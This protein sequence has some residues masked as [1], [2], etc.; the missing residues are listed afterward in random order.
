MGEVMTDS[1][2]PLAELNFGALRTR[3]FESNDA[4][5]RVAAHDAARIIMTAIAERGT[6]NVILATGNSQLT[7]LRHLRDVELE[8]DKVK[9]FHLDQYVGI[10]PDHPASFTHFLNETLL[11]FVSVGEFFPISGDPAAVDKTCREY[12]NLLI[13]NPPDLVALGIGE[14]GHLAFNDPPQ[15]QFDDPALVRVVDLTEPSRHQQVGEGHF[16]SLNDV[17]SKAIT[18]TIPA[19][20]AARSILAI[21]PETRKAD[22]VRRCL[23]QPISEDVPGTVLRLC[24]NASLYLDLN[25]SERVLKLPLA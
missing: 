16:P 11:K 8:W 1:I 2:K 14:N 18:L 12:E 9:V 3:V 5:G 10:E 7:F 15:A 19:L 25:S 21:V 13:K 24:R 6:A 22:I 20:L 17:P 4:L 23:T